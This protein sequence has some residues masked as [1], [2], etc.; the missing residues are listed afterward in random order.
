M[1]W[2]WMLQMQGISLSPIPTKPQVLSQN[3]AKAHYTKPF[4][5]VR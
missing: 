1:C 5:K 3:M 4:R 2:L